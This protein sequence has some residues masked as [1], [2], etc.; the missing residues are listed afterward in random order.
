MEEK[1]DGNLY[2]IRD[3]YI[4]YILSYES[5]PL[6]SNKY[7]RRFIF[8]PFLNQ[9]GMWASEKDFYIKILDFMGDWVLKEVSYPNNVFSSEIVCR[10]QLVFIPKEECMNFSLHCKDS[11]GNITLMIKDIV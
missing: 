6:N 3:G 4:D 2:E 8:D 7:V 9:K 5:I 1:K 11:K 10:G